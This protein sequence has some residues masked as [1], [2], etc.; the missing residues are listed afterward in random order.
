MARF[1]IFLIFLIYLQ[2]ILKMQSHSS[3]NSPAPFSFKYGNVAIMNIYQLFAF[4][5]AQCSDHGCGGSACY[6][7]QVLAA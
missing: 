1:K 7:S 5:F 6:G 4:E 2:V 3:I